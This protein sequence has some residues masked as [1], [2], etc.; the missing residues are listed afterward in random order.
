M[1]AKT[2]MLAY[3]DGN[4]QAILKSRPSLDREAGAG[5]AK[6]L[7]P[8]LPLQ[9]MD[10]VDL[11][12]TCPPDEQVLIGCF[13]GLTIIAAR[14][15]GI[16]YPSQLDRRFLDAANG[17]TVYLHA[18]HSVVDWFAYAIWSNGTL[19]RSL[20]VSPDDGIVEDLGERQQF[21][22]PYWNG[23]RPACDP[24]EDEDSYP[25]PFH[26]L[27]LGEDALLSLFGYQLEGM[28]DPSQLAPET[29]GLQRFARVKPRWKFW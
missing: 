21:E 6:Q 29:V 27:E 5:L 20:S 13:P 18:M 1:G 9:P 11:S 4:A 24:D 22:Q 3:V 15:F 23:E 28:L 2:W 19:Q 10:D 26:P 17:R 16:D 8:S 7:F 14:E 12:Y 25:L